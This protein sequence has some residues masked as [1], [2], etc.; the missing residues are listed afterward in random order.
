MS[1]E[2]KYTLRVLINDWVEEK[3]WE[4]EGEHGLSFYIETPESKFL[5]DCGHT[6]AA[7]RNAVKMGV[8]LSEVDFVALSHSHYDHAGGFPALL[9]HVKPRTLYTGPN[10]WQEKYSYDEETDKYHCK[11]C[12]FTEEE[13]ASW[14]IEQR[15]CRDML[16]LDNYASLF[17][18]F[19]RKYGFET[20]PEKFVRGEDKTPD[21][22]ASEAARDKALRKREGGC[23]CTPSIGILL[24]LRNNFFVTNFQIGDSYST[25]SFAAYHHQMSIRTVQ[26]L[27]HKTV[28]GVTVLVDKLRV[29]SCIV[30]IFTST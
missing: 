14:G 6:G 4:L 18:G 30:I 27:P 25:P 21:S 9:E 23:I 10:F 26:V 17:T 8:D 28:Y 1:C 24:P 19:D 2:A 22:F 7:W 29:P 12:G 15:E 11:G 3:P 16:K 20:I 13:L 5:F